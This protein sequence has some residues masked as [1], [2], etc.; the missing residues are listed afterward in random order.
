MKII[1]KTDIEDNWVALYAG[2][3]TVDD[4]LGTAIAQWL[5]TK[6]PTA[7]PILMSERE[8]RIQ[9][10]FAHQAHYTEFALKWKGRDFTIEE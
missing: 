8:G 10:T 5:R 4:I 9:L 3:M 2:P 7:T 6:L 1:F